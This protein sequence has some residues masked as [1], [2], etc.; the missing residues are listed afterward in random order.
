MFECFLFT[1]TWYKDWIVWRDAMCS[2]KRFAL[3]NK[4]PL[5]FVPNFVVSPVS[6]NLQWIESFY[7][8]G[9]T[10]L[11]SWKQKAIFLSVWI[12]FS[13]CQNRGLIPSKIFSLNLLYVFIFFSFM[14]SLS[15]F[16][17]P[18]YL[19]PYGWQIFPPVCI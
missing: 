18:F 10:C 8:K 17:S 4:N 11:H 6:Q 14:L 15:P 19:L 2:E 13:L 12:M 9:Q 3:K 5:T 7:L 16:H 1:L